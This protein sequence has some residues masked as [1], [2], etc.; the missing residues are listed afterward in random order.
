MLLNNA[1]YVTSHDH[2]GGTVRPLVICLDRAPVTTGIHP[3]FGNCNFPLPLQNGQRIENACLLD[4][5]SS[6]SAPFGSAVLQREAADGRPAKIGVK[7]LVSEEIRVLGTAEFEHLPFFIERLSRD[8]PSTYRKTIV[9][10]GK[11]E[12]AGD[13]LQIEERLGSELRAEIRL[14]LE[15]YDFQQLYPTVNLES[16]LFI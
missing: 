9:E 14:D 5:P 15:L 1:T 8:H 12:I 2:L 6:N 10:I 3:R 7:S 4:Y 16:L 11:F 13:D